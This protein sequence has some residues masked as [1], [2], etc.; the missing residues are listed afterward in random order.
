MNVFFRADRLTPVL[1]AHGLLALVRS[2]LAMGLLSGQYDATSRM[3]ADDVRSRSSEWMDWFKDG[4]MAPDLLDRPAAVRE[5][6]TTGGRTMV[7][8][9][10]GWLWA[11]SGAPS[12]P[13]ASAP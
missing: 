6:L 5:L 2:P 9:A 13:R 4:R 12:P 8:G 11:R 1:E 7:Q 3:A 10:P